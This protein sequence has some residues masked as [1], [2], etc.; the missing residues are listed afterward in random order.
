MQGVVAEMGGSY[1]VFW[2][3]LG[4]NFFHTNLF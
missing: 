2:G 1:G 4:Y 3:M